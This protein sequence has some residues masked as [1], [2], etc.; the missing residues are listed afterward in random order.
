MHLNWQFFVS[1]RDGPNMPLGVELFK[2]E[3]S[4]TL[5]CPLI[6]NLMDQ[7]ASYGTELV[8]KNKVNLGIYQFI[9]SFPILVR[10]KKHNN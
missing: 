8:I 3:L 6:G 7:F 2:S 1:A 10:K 4:K 5:I 9:Y